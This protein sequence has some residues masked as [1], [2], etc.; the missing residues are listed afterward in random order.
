[1]L[2]LNSPGEEEAEDRPCEATKPIQQQIR[3]RCCHY[4]KKEGSKLQREVETTLEQR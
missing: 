2:M 1:M 3:Q 4:G